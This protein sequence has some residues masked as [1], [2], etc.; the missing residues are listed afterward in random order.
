MPNGLYDSHGMTVGA[1][2]FSNAYINTLVQ[3]LCLW[4]GAVSPGTAAA[5]F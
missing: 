2:I 3:V 4:L 1:L 5:D